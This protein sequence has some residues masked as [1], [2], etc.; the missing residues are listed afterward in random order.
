MSSTHNGH[1]HTAN[2]YSDHHEDGCGDWNAATQ[3]Y[4]TCSNKK[5]VTEELS[6]KVADE[7]FSQ[8]NTY[9][10]IRSSP[11]IQDTTNNIKNGHRDTVGHVPTTASLKYE[12]ALQL[13]DN[14]NHLD[15]KC[16]TA[17][18][19]D[20]NAEFKNDKPYQRKC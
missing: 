2:A 3:V 12:R 10:A 8:Q 17:F 16:R 7:F 13:C 18:L 11:S 9:A 5:C 14:E 20:I 1:H 15:G 6:G 4:T 19:K